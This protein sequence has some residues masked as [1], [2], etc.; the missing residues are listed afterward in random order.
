MAVSVPLQPIHRAFLHTLQSPGVRMLMRD[1]ILHMLYHPT[2][3]Y[4]TRFHGEDNLLYRGRPFEF[5]KIPDKHT[6]QEDRDAVEAHSPTWFTP[7]DLCKPYFGRI[8]ADYILRTRGQDQPLVVV[9][10][11]GG[12]GV[13]ARDLLDYLEEHHP[14]VYCSVTYVGVEISHSLHQT[15]KELL[16]RHINAGRYVPRHGNFLEWTVFVPDDCFV[17][18][19]EVLDCLPHDRIVTR[20]RGPPCQTYV[21]I[22]HR[23]ETM[24]AKEN[25]QFILH[26]LSDGPILETLA[27]D[28]RIEG[29][30]LSGEQGLVLKTGTD[31]NFRDF[32]NPVAEFLNRI[33]WVPTDYTQLCNVLHRFF[34]R[35]RLLAIDLSELG[36]ER[37]LEG[38]NAPRMQA[39]VMMDW[40]STY[41]T[42]HFKA[43]FSMPGRAD[44]V[45]PV[46]FGAAR[47]I[48]MHTAPVSAPPRLTEVTG[49]LDFA[50]RYGG[51]WAPNLQL[52]DG[53][54][55]LEE[56]SYYKVLTSLPN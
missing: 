40:E 17:V 48:Y 18:M 46:D 28:G 24:S 53:T 21:E 47:R 49:L 35:H 39:K 38:H 8:I 23:D 11:G 5:P 30:E 22:P 16:A 52:G 10:V 42:H 37:R 43:V 54:N 27:Y 34:P 4:Y 2:E 36:P 44:I 9:E 31:E 50:K 12:S 55:V 1:W 19:H 6:L 20:A 33:W 25:K 45:F 26:N 15:Q 29:L 32:N 51:L 7:V 3:G 14:E 13:L 41:Q 56:Y